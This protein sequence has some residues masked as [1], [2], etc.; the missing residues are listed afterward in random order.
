[1]NEVMEG[2]FQPLM[3]GLLHEDMALKL[4]ELGKPQQSL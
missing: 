1:L 2:A 3:S 4:A